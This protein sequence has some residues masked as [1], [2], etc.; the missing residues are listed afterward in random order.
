MSARVWVVAVALCGLGAVVRAQQTQPGLVLTI[1]PRAAREG[2]MASDARVAPALALFVGLNEAPSAFVGPGLFEATFVGSIELPARDDYVF[3]FAGVGSL[4]LEIDGALVLEGQGR[5]GD[6]PVVGASTRLRRGVRALV[7]RY[8]T[9]LSGIAELRVSWEGGK[10]PR[11]AIPPTALSHDPALPELVGGVRRRE[12]RMQLA[13]LR[14]TACHALPFDLAKGMPELAMRGPSLRDAGTRLQPGWMAQWIADPRAL[15][16]G[17]R[18][19]RMLHGEQVAQDAADLAVFLASLGA[20]STT[21]PAT[22]D[23]TRGARVWATLGCFT[24]HSLDAADEGAW[25]AL[26]GVAAKYRAGALAEFI[27]HPAAREPWIRMPDLHLTP[28]E[29][30]DL[31]AFLRVGTAET[32]IE[33]VSGD[34][35]RGRVLFAASGCADCHDAGV[36]SALAAP[37]LTAALGNPAGGCLAVERAAQSGVPDF[38]LTTGQ[39]AALRQFAAVPM[40]SLTHDPR[41]EFVDRQLVERRCDACHQIGA[42][43]SL[44][45]RREEI[46]VGL[47]PP[48]AVIEGHVEVAQN[49]PALTWVGEKLR[50]DWTER[51]LRGDTPSPRPWLHARMPRFPA[52]QARALALGLAARAGFGT[53]PV[54]TVNP[55]L[56]ATGRQLIGQQGGFSCI[57]CHGVAGTLPV[58]L[59][60]VQGI[61]LALVAPRLRHDYYASWM[62]D[63]TRY[64][65][66]SK[67]PRFASEELKTALDA[68][69]G[70]AALQYEA[71]WAWLHA[72]SELKVKR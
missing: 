16:P 51:F 70:D 3:S 24:C 28:A 17:A 63:P 50:I 20:E 55:A 36:T 40:A 58:A 57:T 6:R 53:D 68:C 15:R 56:V 42:T 46:A 1:E 71:I 32:A 33:A 29:A 7:A 37:D 48:S 54:V 4:R 61:D 47:A 8:R 35:A 23:A 34:A 67:M 2:S 22:G 72:A 39:R 66:A 25:L 31:E 9:P 19:P 26:S 43:P 27:A 69:G 38:G 10:L 21:R 13:T 65:P 60:E 44:W 45:T 59:F 64:D 49:R 41:A 12:G 62:M 30:V 11:Q 14:C 18:M 52:D 5:G